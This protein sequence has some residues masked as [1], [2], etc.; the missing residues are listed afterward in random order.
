MC[1]HKKM[2]LFRATS[3][4]KSGKWVIIRGQSRGICCQESKQLS[5]YRG[6]TFFHSFRMCI[7]LSGPAWKETV[8]PLHIRWC[9]PNYLSHMTQLIPLRLPETLCLPTWL[10][11]TTYR[12]TI[13]NWKTSIVMLKNVVILVHSTSEWVYFMSYTSLFCVMSCLWENLEF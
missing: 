12:S 4:R 1:K 3:Y 7:L 6:A 5:N 13:W 8:F 9:C 2:V 10:H 11:V